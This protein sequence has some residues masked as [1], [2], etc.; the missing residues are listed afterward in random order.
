LQAGG[1]GFDPPTLHG[2]GSKA[3]DESGE[4]R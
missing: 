4:F 2:G 1:Q 3:L